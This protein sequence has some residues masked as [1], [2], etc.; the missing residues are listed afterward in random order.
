MITVRARGAGSERFGVE[1]ERVE[2]TPS[3]G[4]SFLPAARTAFSASTWIAAHPREFVLQGG[5]SQVVEYSIRVPVGVEPGDHLGAVTVKQLRL[6]RATVAAVQAIAVRTTIRVPGRIRQAVV[7]GEI[8]TPALASGGPVTVAT[9]V[10]NTGDVRLDFNANN[11]AAL[12]IL[13]GSKVSAR[14][15][16]IGLLYPG[17]VRS[18]RLTWQ[19]PP[20]FGKLKARVSVRLSNGPRSNTASFWMVPWR[21]AGAVL[22]IA[23]A[24]VVIYVQRKR[25]RS[26]SRVAEAGR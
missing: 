25:R 19:D 7:L 12:A 22:L 6:G 23:L 9:T 26:R 3:G 11:P 16:F 5:R 2:Q 24:A 20:T 21:Q 18:F 10:R 14:L 15:P 13:D 8:G 4:Y 17:Q 1:V